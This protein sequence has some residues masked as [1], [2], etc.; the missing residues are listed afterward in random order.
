MSCVTE[1]RDVLSANN[2]A[3]EDRSS[4]TSFMHFKNNND[5]QSGTLRNVCGDISPL[6][7]FRRTLCFLSLKK[8]NKWYKR[9]KIYH[10][11]SI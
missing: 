8:V 7:C 3:L 1:D 10:F 6:R 11:P 5:P 9:F 2:F 4:N